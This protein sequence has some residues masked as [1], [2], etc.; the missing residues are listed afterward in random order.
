MP[1]QAVPAGSYYVAGDFNLWGFE[2]MASEHP[3]EVAGKW[4]SHVAEVTLRGDE[5]EFQALSMARRL[6]AVARW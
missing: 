4:R 2:L 5:D 6:G 1:P 3:E